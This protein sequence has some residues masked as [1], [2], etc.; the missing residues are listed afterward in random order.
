VAQPQTVTFA[1]GETSPKTISF[2]LVAD[3]LAEGTE[4]A[5]LQLQAPVGGAT[6]GTLPATILGDF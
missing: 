6:L 1:D 3:G 2:N 5:I 4:T